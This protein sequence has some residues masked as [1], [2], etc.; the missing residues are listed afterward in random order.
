MHPTQDIHARTKVKLLTNR[1]TIHLELLAFSY[2]KDYKYITK[3]K[4]KTRENEV[5]LLIQT[6]SS[7]IGYEISALK[8]SQRV[9]ERNIP[10]TVKY[11]RHLLR[12]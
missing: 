5:P 10:D 9:E 3:P 4:R 11:K 2:S 7:I 1:K 6:R 8:I 12:Q